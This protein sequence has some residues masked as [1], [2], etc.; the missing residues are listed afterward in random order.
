MTRPVANPRFRRGW[1]IEKRRAL[2]ESLREQEV[3]KAIRRA[4]KLHLSSTC[5][6]GMAATGGADP[7]YARALHQQCRGELPGGI[8]C[9]CL[10]H[11]VIQVET[12]AGF[13]SGT[14]PLPDQPI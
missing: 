13:A 11:D 1:S 12:E 5:I 2:R 10:C 6:N 14:V 8:G 7:G 4:E 9:L 3:E